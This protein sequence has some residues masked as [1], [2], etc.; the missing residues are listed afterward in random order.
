VGGAQTLIP[1]SS[2]M[3]APVMNALSP[4]ARKATSWADLG[5]R[6]SPTSACLDVA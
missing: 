3:V 5:V 2:G 1:P 4:E 6:M